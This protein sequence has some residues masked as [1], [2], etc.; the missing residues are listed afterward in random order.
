VTPFSFAYE[1][2]YSYCATG[3][4]FNRGISGRVLSGPRV[5]EAEAGTHAWA[6]EEGAGGGRHGGHVPGPAPS[7]V[8]VKGEAVAHPSPNDPGEA[9]AKGFAKPSTAAAQGGHP[10]T[11]SAAGAKAGPSTETK[12]PHDVKPAEPGAKDKSPSSALKT[13]TEHPPAKPVAPPS[14]G[15]K[16]EK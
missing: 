15:G 5:H 13:P 16:K 3:D 9:K 2:R 11:K 7:K 12:S 14:G 4:L 1:P 10:P 6:G 8:G